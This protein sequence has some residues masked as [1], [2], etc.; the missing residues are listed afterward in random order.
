MQALKKSLYK[1]S[2]PLFS[3]CK[4]VLIYPLIVMPLTFGKIL[5]FPSIIK[6]KLQKYYSNRLETY[7]Q[8]P[9]SIRLFYY[10]AA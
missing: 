10:Y 3:D 2:T 6:F 7:S 8:L 4:H 1:A 5:S 9:K